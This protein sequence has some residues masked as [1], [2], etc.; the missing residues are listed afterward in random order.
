[1]GARRR[2]PRGPGG[3]FGLGG[4]FLLPL[5]CLLLLLLPGTTDSLLSGSI[6]ATD[7][8]GVQP[9]GYVS[10]LL[11]R[12]TDSAGAPASYVGGL[13]LGASRAVGVASGALLNVA[14]RGLAWDVTSTTGTY[15]INLYPAV[16]DNYTL[17]LLVGDAGD[18]SAATGAVA[19]TGL[20]IAV[21]VG[22]LATAALGGT[23]LSGGAAVA[24][25]G[26]TL[27]VQ[28]LDA[29]GNRV[30]SGVATPALVAY[31]LG[32]F[33]PLT[34]S[35][36]GGAYSAAGL[37]STSSPALTSAGRLWLRVAVNVSGGAGPFAALGGPQ[38]F[39]V[40]PGPASAAQSKIVT[41]QSALFGVVG[42]AVRARSWG[43]GERGARARGWALG[44]PG[45]VGGEFR[46]LLLPSFVPAGGGPWLRPLTHF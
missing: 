26:G 45:R 37:W 8:S 41:A 38:L 11:L 34:A 28:P 18:V 39:V 31:Y 12:L 33:P 25:G 2:G 43:G 30:T 1:M 42:T 7:T 35:I 10:S 22:P 17:R 19:G 16:A 5:V 27:S 29:C 3:R 44:L 40:S 21:G 20:T 36:G 15:R 32:A 9:A 23:L 13:N 6:N 14:N 4:L 24:A 46:I